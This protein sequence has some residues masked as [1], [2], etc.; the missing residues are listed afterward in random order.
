M[1]LMH[2]QGA[3]MIKASEQMMIGSS[4]LTAIICLMNAFILMQAA[5]AE[6]KWEM[7][8]NSDG[9]CTY[10]RPIPGSDLVEYKSMTVL[11]TSMEVIGE[12]LRDIP[13]QPQWMHKCS[14][15]HIVKKF[16]R[17]NLIFYTVIGTPFPAK[18]RDLVVSNK[19][20]Y[21][22][23]MARAIIIA[24]PTNEPPVPLQNDRVRITDFYARFI[25]EFIGRNKTGIIYQYR[26]DPGGNLPGV[27]VNI[28]SKSISH[29]TLIGLKRLVQNS[30]YI[31][32]AKTSED[33]EIFNRI[34]NNRLTTKQILRNRLGEYIKNKYI[35]ELML[36]DEKIINMLIYGSGEIAEI[37]F[38]GS[39][40]HSSITTAAKKLLAVYLKKFI[41]NDET[42]TLMLKEQAIIDMLIDDRGEL[43]KIISNGRESRESIIDAGKKI[44]AVYLSKFIKNDD[45]ITLVTKERKIIE[46]LMDDKGEIAKIVLDGNGTRKSIVEAG[47]K[48][49]AV[50]LNKYIKNEYTITLMLKEDAIIFML[51]DEKGEIAKILLRGNGSSESIHTVAKKLF[52]VYLKKFIHN[53]ETISLIV[54]EDMII[55]MLMDDKGEMAKIVLQG[56]ESRESFLT[57]GRKMFAVYL[58]K[59]ITDERLIDRIVND[60]TVI[61]MLMRNK[62]SN[63]GT[64]EADIISYLKIHYRI[65]DATIKNV[66][67]L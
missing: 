1:S 32:A 64:L 21:D 54:K 31:M 19:T 38:M 20:T 36:N 24:N 16:D 48:L 53:E 4:L 66:E 60:D 10:S 37:V 35:I 11:N 57:A 2:D 27:V 47:K 45:L 58:K 23:N 42:I 13:A 26:A 34:Y 61:S 40:S 44:L 46:K 65:D 5:H 25:I 39:G 62:R 51:L 52:A 50:Y 33:K 43:A 59:Y 8:R 56:N 30:K 49:L 28:F 6:F 3:I 9:I 22:L 41:K 29:E 12:A 63:K 15:S 67:E 7:I 55:D 18:N 14:E 17:N